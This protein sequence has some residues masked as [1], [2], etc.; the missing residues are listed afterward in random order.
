VVLVAG[1]TGLLAV[2]PASADVPGEAIVVVD[3]TR[4]ADASDSF[5]YG[6]VLVDPSRRRVFLTDA[7][8]AMPRVQVYDHANAAAPTR[9]AS[10]NASP[11]G[12]P[13]REIAWY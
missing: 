5:T 7:N 3:P 6:T 12:L 8:A 4:L 13:S 10:I 2:V 9:E 1:T 11:T